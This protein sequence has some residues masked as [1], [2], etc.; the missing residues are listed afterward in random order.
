MNVI[1]QVSH[2]WDQILRFLAPLVIPDW[3]SLVGLLPIFLVVGVLGPLLGLLALIWVVYVV[4]RPRARL[5][6]LIT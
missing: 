4:R 2:I 5:N 6:G 1:D 3:G